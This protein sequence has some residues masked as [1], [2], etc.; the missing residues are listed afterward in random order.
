MSPN[1][2]LPVLLVLLSGAVSHAQAPRRARK[3]AAAAQAPVAREYQNRTI[4]V[5]D[6][7]ANTVPEVRIAARTPTTLVFV[8]PLAKGDEAM[9]LAAPPNVLPPPVYNSRSLVL[10]PEVDLAPGQSLPLTLTFEG[11]H[12]QTFKL[13]TDPKTVDLK[14]EVALALKERAAPDNS[15]AL[16][17][18]VNQLRAQLDECQST[19][20]NA[21]IQKMA[22]LIVSQ[23]FEKPGAF[24]VE[25]VTRR[26]L[27]RQSRLLVEVRASYRLFGQTYVVL[28][29]QNRDP[30]KI[31][32][33]DRPEVAVT[34]SGEAADAK[35]VTYSAEMSSLPPDE[36]EKIVV[37]FNT[38]PQQKGQTYDISL[39]EKS[40][41][42]HVKLEDV[43]L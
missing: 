17:T 42:R 5:T 43:E 28:T 34:G 4:T 31:W 40:G 29:V 7:T 21:G 38:P 25:R 15:A 2:L 9:L 39:M 3:P 12:V 13:V 18:T 1:A 6:A 10:V 35:V 32:V 22:S 19:S 16:N 41:S 26:F 30:S 20:A 37:V 11:G 14:V 36:V 23:D 27:D 33:L 8:Q 24:T